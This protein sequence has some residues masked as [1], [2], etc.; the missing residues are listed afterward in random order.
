M[1]VRY[2]YE[3]D[4][5]YVRYAVDPHPDDR[6]F[7]MHVHERYEIF[8]FISGHA[9]Y[10]VEGSKYPLEPG[11]LMLM[12]PAESH[13]IKILGD[14]PYE[15]IAVNFPRSILELIDP[16]YLLLKPFEDRPIGRGNFYGACEFH[17]ASLNQLFQ[18]MCSEHQENYH[19]RAKILAH[20]FVILD[21]INDAYIKRG[22]AEYVPPQSLSEQIVAHVNMHL[23]D[24]LSI[25]LLAEHFFLSTSQFSRIF[26]Q[27]TGAAP[28]EY[29]TIKRLTAAREKIRS[30]IPAQNASDNCGFKD[31]SSFY[32][33]YVKHFGCAPKN[34]SPIRALS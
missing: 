15:R 32:R 9:Q 5:L 22:S 23:F 12:R 26:R 20:L 16:Q 8:Y 14:A 19:K 10:L 17:Q 18:K 34:D 25:P 28:W 29:I 13:R 11:S 24:D 3:T 31:Y 33:A 21:M 30:G 4:E 7:Q 1:D 6:D 27:A 2:F